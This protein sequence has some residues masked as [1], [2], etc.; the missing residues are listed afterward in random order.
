MDHIIFYKEGISLKDQISG[1]RITNQRIYTQYFPIDKRELDYLLENGSVNYLLFYLAPEL[2][3]EDISYLRRINSDH[4]RVKV[5]LFSDAINALVAWRIQ[6][7]HFDTYPVISNQLEIAYRKYVSF[8]V[9]KEKVLKVKND[10][11]VFNIP[12]RNISFLHAAGNYT[13]IYQKSDKSLLITRQLGT[14]TEL[15]EID[16][17]MMRVHRSMIINLGNID[18]CIASK[19]YFFDCKKPLNISSSLEAKVKR[20]LIQNE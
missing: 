14:F 18:R 12:Y 10:S 20:I 15:E 17:Y 3:D 7:F 13:M 8:H 1:I 2:N 5:V 9:S 19:I 6:V 16:P 11:G 4:E